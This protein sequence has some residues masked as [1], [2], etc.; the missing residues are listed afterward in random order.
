[1]L[2]STGHRR[3]TRIAASTMP[4]RRCSGRAALASTPA[5]NRSNSRRTP[6]L[7][8]NKRSILVAP[9]ASS[10]ASWT[11]MRRSGSNASATPWQRPY[12]AAA[13]TVAAIAPT[14]LPPMPLKR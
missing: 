14:E 9:E 7:G 13:A 8:W 4:L 11:G 10:S 5:R 12:S 1:V 6:A 3:Y 2:T